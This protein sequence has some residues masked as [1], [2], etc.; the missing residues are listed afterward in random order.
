LNEAFE[1]S[2][3]IE[4]SGGSVPVVVIVVPVF[5]VVVPVVSELLVAVSMLFVAVLTASEL[6]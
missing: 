6:M 4:G 1:V 2:S 3:V 5:F